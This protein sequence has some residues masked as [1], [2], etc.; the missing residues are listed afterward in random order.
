M[1]GRDEEESWKIRFLRIFGRA[2]VWLSVTDSKI[3]GESDFLGGI[4]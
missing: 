4:G 1:P 2:H 3:V